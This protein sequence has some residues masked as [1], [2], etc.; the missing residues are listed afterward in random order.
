MFTNDLKAY[1]KRRILFIP[2][3]TT[4]DESDGVKR[5]TVPYK[6]GKI[7]LEDDVKEEFVS[8]T[9]DCQ[10]EGELRLYKRPVFL[11]KVE[12]EYIEEELATKDDLTDMLNAIV[13][14][15][16]LTIAKLKHKVNILSII[17]P[18][19]KEIESKLQS[20]EYT[21]DDVNM[22]VSPTPDAGG[23]YK[24][25]I[26]LDKDGNEVRDPITNYPKLVKVTDKDFVPEINPVYPEG[27]WDKEPEYDEDGNLI[28]KDNYYIN[29]VTGKPVID[30]NTG[31][32]LLIP[33]D[34][35]VDKN[36]CLDDEGRIIIKPEYLLN[37]KG[38]PIIDKNTGLPI[39]DPEY[40]RKQLEGDKEDNT[41]TDGN[42]R[43]PDDGKIPPTVVDPTPGYNPEDNNPGKPPVDENPNPDTDNT[44][45][46]GEEVQPDTPDTEN[47]DG[48]GETLPSEG[49]GTGTT[50][51]EG[52]DTGS[53]PK[54]PDSTTGTEN[55]EGGTDPK[56][57][58]TENVVGSDKDNNADLTSPTENKNPDP[59]S[60]KDSVDGVQS[61]TT[62]TDPKESVT[63][64]QDPAQ[65][66][67]V[68]EGSRPDEEVP[69][70]S[71]GA[72]TDKETSDIKQGET[73][74]PD[75]GV[76]TVPNASDTDVDAGD[77]PDGSV[78]ESDNSIRLPD[79]ELN[80]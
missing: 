7:L 23:G 45:G 77:R 69:A 1:T 67:T 68:E 44:E 3:Y 43:I 35:I 47:Q 74:G 61:D 65:G 5:V 80:S 21:Y 14:A 9:K 37:S 71:V 34:P 41:G 36:V 6:D 57:D 2:E 49:D 10:V 15:F 76:N 26:A 28:I 46:S 53:T 29:K 56:P 19:Y 11:K 16:D 39:I 72:P 75:T 42:D 18:D 48:T 51:E 52:E 64:T 70:G 63:E 40:I 58:D 30:K 8:R 22:T 60:G 79:A 31:W 73:N 25:I 17:S 38:L 55:T 66:D 13:N 62:E 50:P 59:D 24:W 78:V 33:S 4:G 20:G 27:M 54:E 32:V 12:D